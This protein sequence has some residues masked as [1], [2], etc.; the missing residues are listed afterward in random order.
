MSADPPQ[1]RRPFHVRLRRRRTISREL[2]KLL[3]DDHRPD[4][5]QA[6]AIPSREPADVARR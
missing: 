3:D 5:E 1:L 4:V 6:Y 2:D